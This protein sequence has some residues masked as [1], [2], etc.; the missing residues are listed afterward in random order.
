[1]AMGY[2]V[3]SMSMT[4]LPKVKWVIRNIK[5]RDARRILARVLKMD[6]AEEV[7]R[8]VNRQLMDAGLER[9][10]SRLAQVG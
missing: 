4:H 10:S 8:Y 1:M 9:V 6:T 3:L 2:H 5:R 7:S